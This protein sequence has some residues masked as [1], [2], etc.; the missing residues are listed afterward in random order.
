MGVINYIL[1]IAKEYPDL[2]AAMVGLVLSWCATQ[3]FKKMI[4]DN[5]SDGA[6]RR[7]VQ[8]IGFV[9]GWG[10][11]H[12]AWILFDPTS[13]HFEKFYASA[14]VGFASPA[15]YSLAV[16]YLAE[17]YQ[18]AKGLSGRPSEEPPK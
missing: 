1:G 5:I 3:F 13:S 15:L 18:W 7:A 10:F 17:K 6:Y 14:G 8:G 11:A 16:S 2:A 12:G 4:P 9:T